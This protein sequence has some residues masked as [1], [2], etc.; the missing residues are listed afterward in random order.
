MKEAF[1]RARFT[2]HLKTK[3]IDVNKMHSD[4]VKDAEAAKKRAASAQSD[5]DSFRKKT[6]VTSESS[7]DFEPHMMY[8]PKTG[9]GTMAKVEAD[10]IRMKKMG[11]S[12]DK[13]DV[14][15]SV[16]DL[17]GHTAR[18][19]AT[20]LRDPSHPMHAAAKA[21]RDRRN[22]TRESFKTFVEATYSDSGWQKPKDNSN[23]SDTD[24][25]NKAKKLARK[26]N[27]L[28][29]V[30]ASGRTVPTIKPVKEA[31]LRPSFAKKVR[32]D[33]LNKDK[34]P[35][36]TGKTTG[37]DDYDFLKYKNKKKPV[38]ET[39]GAPKGYHFTRDGKLKKGDAGADGDG[40]AK[41]R[42]DPL[43]KQRSKIPPIPEKF[44]NPA[45]QAAVMA[46][47]KKSGKYDGKESKLDELSTKTLTSYKGKADYSREKAQNSAAANYMRGT[48]GSGGRNDPD[49]KTMQ[50]R[51]TGSQLYYGQ[52]ANKLRKKLSDLKKEATADPATVRMMKDN[53]HMIGQKGP[54][55]MKSLNKNTQKK[56]KQALGKDAMKKE[57]TIPDGQTVMTKG[58]P[59]KKN[60][61][62]KL[63]KIRM[64]LNREKKK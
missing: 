37:P 55:G 5:L 40:G 12:H 42:S 59:I 17:S 8:D 35:A 24:G 26:G 18:R 21:E 29:K 45:Q 23:M 46:K 38:A 62:D 2:Q 25:M 10:H 47:L 31:G 9:K 22:M 6:G 34:G 60:D 61:M 1:G 57:A 41:L 43:D 50:K 13:P 49:I 28:A 15:E 48:K 39:K 64:M 14:K 11:Y 36:P 54:G 56:V 53:P 19:L 3:G 16:E 33:I 51:D 27:S 30:A 4:N 20:I 32:N 63:A 7:D 44:A 52:L 58:D